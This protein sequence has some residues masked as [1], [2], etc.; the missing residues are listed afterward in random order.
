VKKSRGRVRAKKPDIT[1]ETVSIARHAVRLEVGWL[2]E[3]GW[4]DN[5]I[6]GLWSRLL[7]EYASAST[8]VRARKRR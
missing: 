5:E 3:E 6:L 2:R 7:R 1:A 8:R 4:T